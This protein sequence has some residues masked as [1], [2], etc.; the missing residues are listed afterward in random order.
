MY[1]QGFL[2]LE[3]SVLDVEVWGLGGKTAQEIQNSYKKREELFN[4]QRRKVNPHL[5]H[6]L[7]KDVH[8]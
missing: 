8:L 1:I 5:G 6:F 2:P 4:E 7:W 3:G